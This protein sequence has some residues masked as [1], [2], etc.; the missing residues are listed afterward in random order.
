MFG[1]DEVSARSLRGVSELRLN[2][3][4]IIRIQ[5]RFPHPE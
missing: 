4:S 1:D 2:A 3:H 5:L